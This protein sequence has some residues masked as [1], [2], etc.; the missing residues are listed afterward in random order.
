[1]S[2]SNLRKKE[3]SQRILLDSYE[4]LTLGLK[5]K[6]ELAITLK[7]GLTLGWV[8]FVGWLESPPLKST[9]ITLVPSYSMMNTMLSCSPELS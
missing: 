1:M 4:E 3:R 7:Q 9:S 6:R 8:P 5:S 2:Y